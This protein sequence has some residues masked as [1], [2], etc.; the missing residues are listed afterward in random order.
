M[1]KNLKTIIEEL[2][3]KPQLHKG[4]ADD[5][6]T[7]SRKLAKHHIHPNIQLLKKLTEYIVTKEKP[8]VKTLNRLALFAGFQN[9]NDLQT[10][11]HGDND[12]QL[13]Y[14]D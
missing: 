3:H 1:K 5:L 8:S 10:A 14:E 4:S 2:G 6:E 11:L 9:W 13:N 7:L 12:A